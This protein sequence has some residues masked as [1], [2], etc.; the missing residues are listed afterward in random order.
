MHTSVALLG[1]YALPWKT[2]K[3]HPK[4]P[5]FFDNCTKS[6]INSQISIV[7]YCLTKLQFYICLQHYAFKLTQM[8]GFISNMFNPQHSKLNQKQFLKFKPNEF[9]LEKVF[10]ANSESDL[11]TS[12]RVKFRKWKRSRIFSLHH[13]K[14]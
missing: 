12:F 1:K 5:R 3:E 8:L 11:H 9:L 10:W 7:M 14:I 2:A 13:N 4:I 6:S